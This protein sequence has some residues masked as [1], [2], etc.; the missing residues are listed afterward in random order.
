MYG[1]PELLLVSQVNDLSTR[2]L[3]MVELYLDWSVKSQDGHRNF[4]GTTKTRILS[5]LYVLMYF[6]RHPHYSSNVRDLLHF[7]K[8]NKTGQSKTFS[9]VQDQKS[10]CMNINDIITTNMIGSTELKNAE[11]TFTFL[12]CLQKNLCTKIRAGFQL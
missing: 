10:V 3:L 8:A 12:H 5:I 11:T 6:Q 1:V 9:Q 4:R 2:I 7:E